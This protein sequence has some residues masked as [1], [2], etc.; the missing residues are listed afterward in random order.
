MDKKRLFLAFDGSFLKALSAIWLLIQAYTK[1]HNPTVALSFSGSMLSYE[2][3]KA[4]GAYEIPL[5][6]IY[7]GY[8]VVVNPST[9]GSFWPTSLKTGIDNETA[10][11]FH[12]PLVQKMILDKR[13]SVDLNNMPA[14]SLE[15]C[16]AIDHFLAR[17]DLSLRDRSA[18]RVKKSS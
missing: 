14:G 7:I 18:H 4:V 11:A 8:D 10:K 15:H 17:Y 2:I 6:I 16:N 1:M 3:E 9:S 12:L 13:K 5:I